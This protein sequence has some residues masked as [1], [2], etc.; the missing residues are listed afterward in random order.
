MKIYLDDDVAA[1]LLARLL[2]QA[3]HDVQTPVEAG[4]A[5]QH[6][7]AHLTHAIQSQ[8]VLISG[9]HDDFEVLHHLVIA[10]SG[11]HSGILI[12]RRDNDLRRDLSPRGIVVAVGKLERAVSDLTDCFYMLNH[13][14]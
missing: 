14:R 1:A 10:S 5:G 3:G 9:N 8:R 12:V 11:H 2:R 7:A 13:W 4:I 6:D